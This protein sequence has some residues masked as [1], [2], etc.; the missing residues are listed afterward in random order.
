MPVFVIDTPPADELLDDDDDEL[1][2]GLAPPEPMVEVPPFLSK[3]VNLQNPVCDLTLNGPRRMTEVSVVL[4]FS[5]LFFSPDVSALYRF[6]TTWLSF[7][8][9]VTSS[10]LTDTLSE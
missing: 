4:I 10:L 9:M 6:V 1:P 7:V 5:K 3:V 8:A 2:P